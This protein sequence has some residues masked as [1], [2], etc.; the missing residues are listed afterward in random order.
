MV[1]KAILLRIL[2]ALLVGLLFVALLSEVS[3]RL[4][5]AGAPVAEM[6]IGATEHAFSPLGSRVEAI[7]VAGIPMEALLA[8]Y[9]LVLWPVKKKT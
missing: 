3:Y 1:R 8:V 6:A 7:L 9:S 2:P 4:L 5:Q